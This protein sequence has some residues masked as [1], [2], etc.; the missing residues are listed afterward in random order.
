MF[1]TF[2]GTRY[3]E[4]NGESIPK[5]FPTHPTYQNPIFMNPRILLCKVSWIFGFSVVRPIGPYWIFSFSVYWIF[6]F[7]AYFPAL[8]F[9]GGGGSRPPH[10][11]P[12]FLPAAPAASTK[13]HGKSMEK[14]MGN[15][16]KIHGKSMGNQWKINGKSIGNPW[17]INFPWENRFPFENRFSM[18]KSIFHE[19]IGFPWDPMGPRGRP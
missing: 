13:I 10:T 6:S 19:K 4:K 9:V 16:W 15:P 1:P 17:K 12:H 11:P 7:S 5:L 2:C 8:R 18:R 14:S 3:R